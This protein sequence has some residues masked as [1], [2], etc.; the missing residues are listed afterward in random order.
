MVKTKAP[1]ERI[2]TIYLNRQEVAKLH[3]SPYHLDELAIGFLINDGFVDSYGDISSVDADERSLT[4]SIGASSVNSIDGGTVHRASGCGAAS[5]LFKSNFANRNTAPGAICLGLNVNKMMKEMLKATKLYSETGG[6]HCSALTDGNAVVAVR[7]DIGR[8]NTFD[9]LIG[10][11]ALNS[12]DPAKLMVV[13][14]GRI[15]YEMM[16]KIALAGFPQVGSLTAATD[17]ATDL[18]KELGI[19]VFGYVRGASYTIYNLPEN[20]KAGCAN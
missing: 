5:R 1:K 13:T 14:T 2:V 4:V 10:Y 15:S 17:L 12:L 19:I 16:Y 20:Q 6:V 8:H 11:A 3:C 9:K 7:E 18:A